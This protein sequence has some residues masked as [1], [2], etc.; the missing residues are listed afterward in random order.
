MPLLE[1]TTTEEVV[2]EQNRD[3]PVVED[4]IAWDLDLTTIYGT[5][6]T[7]RFEDGMD[8]ATQVNEIFSA[9]AT[10]AGTPG[11]NVRITR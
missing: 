10:A 3:I 5:S 4:L 8:A 1:H 2:V 6:T 7:P 9:A 11:G